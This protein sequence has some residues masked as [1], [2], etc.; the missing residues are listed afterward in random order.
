MNLNNSVEY[1][2][3]YSLFGQKIKDADLEKYDTYYKKFLIGE[4]NIDDFKKFETESIKKNLNEKYDSIFSND[5]VIMYLIT[6]HGLPVYSSVEQKKLFSSSE[7]KDMRKKQIKFIILHLY[8][9]Y[10]RSYIY[11]LSS[12]YR[13]IEHIIEFNGT[14]DLT[15]LVK[16]N[17]EKNILIIHDT[18][19]KIFFVLFTDDLFKNDSSIFDERFSEGK[20]G[21]FKSELEIFN[22]LMKLYFDYGTDY[23]RVKVHYKLGKISPYSSL[24][25]G[26]IGS[27]HK[28]KLLSKQNIFNDSIRIIMFL[29]R[30]LIDYYDVY[31]TKELDEYT[32]GEVKIYYTLLYSNILPLFQSINMHLTKYTLSDDPATNLIILRKIEETLVSMELK[33]NQPYEKNINQL[34]NL[35]SNKIFHN[36]NSLLNNIN[37]QHNDS[38]IFKDLSTARYNSADQMLTGKQWV[39]GHFHRFHSIV[40]TNN[41]EQIVRYCS[42]PEMFNDNKQI[43]IRKNVGLFWN[44]SANK[45][46]ILA[47]SRVNLLFPVRLY[48]STT[49]ITFNLDEF[50]K[51]KIVIPN[52][53]NLTQL[54]IMFNVFRPEPLYLFKTQHRNKTSRGRLIGTTLSIQITDFRLLNIQPG[55]F[56][57]EYSM[58][59]DEINTLTNY[60]KMNTYEIKT[61]NFVMYFFSY[62]DFTAKSEDKLLNN[63][64]YYM[65]DIKQDDIKKIVSMFKENYT[66]INEDDEDSIP[67]KK[68]NI[69]KQEKEN[70]NKNKQTKENQNEIISNIH[71]LYNNSNK[72]VLLKKKSIKFT[73]AKNIMKFEETLTSPHTSHRSGQHVHSEGK[74]DGGRNRR[75][76]SIIKYNISDKIYKLS[77]YPMLYNNIFL[78]KYIYSK[79]IKLYHFQIN[80]YNSYRQSI[81]RNTTVFYLLYPFSLYIDSIKENKPIKIENIKYK[82]ANIYGS[83]KTILYLDLYYNI[84]KQINSNNINILVLN[85]KTETLKYALYLF[86]KNNNISLD[87]CVIVFNLYKIKG[88]AN[89]KSNNKNKSTYRSD[90]GS[91]ISSGKINIPMN[92]KFNY[93]EK[94]I[95]YNINYKNFIDEKTYDFIIC[96]ISNLDKLPLYS[97]MVTEYINRDIYLDELIV[98]LLHLDKGG[99]ILLKV[100]GLTSLLLNKIIYNISLLFNDFSIVAPNTGALYSGAVQHVIFKS[101]KKNKK[102]IEVIDILQKLSKQFKQKNIYNSSNIEFD[103]NLK[104]VV[105]PDVNDIFNPTKKYLNNYTKLDNFSTKYVNY[106]NNINNLQWF[107]RLIYFQ[108]MIYFIK[109]IV[110]KPD[111]NKTEYI[112]KQYHKQIICSYLYSLTTPSKFLRDEFNKLNFNI[113]DKKIFESIYQ[114]PAICEDLIDYKC[115]N[116]LIINQVKNKLKIQTIKEKL[117]NDLY[118]PIAD[119]IKYF[120]EFYKVQ[121]LEELVSKEQKINDVLKFTKKIKISKAIKISKKDILYLNDLLSIKKVLANISNKD[122]TVLF[123]LDIL[124]I[125]KKTNSIQDSITILLYHFKKVHLWKSSFDFDMSTI[126]FIGRGFELKDKLT[127][128][129][130]EKCR[131][132][133]SK[134]INVLLHNLNEFYVDRDM[135]PTIYTY[136]NIL[137]KKHRKGLVKYAKSKKY[138]K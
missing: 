37:E 129:M 55:M 71:K 13:L 75:G 10:A 110:I 86:S 73:T 81:I 132:N 114:L 99:Y 16:Q 94:T 93:K 133:I 64:I 134:Y 46:M 121:K 18:N 88:Y 137:S 116:Q 124:D 105:H 126:Y 103:L 2:F 17:R 48:L 53:S 123:K 97:A 115:Y 22:E 52:L 127:K 85:N 74:I 96:T 130:I 1:L 76:G 78:S 69:N 23:N 84:I 60:L 32:I 28:D 5:G 30:G 21:K 77:N 113:T 117:D 131:H 108:N 90:R 65:F 31:M 20:E 26:N 111:F 122:I 54:G 95:T 3:K 91:I 42:C 136:Y 125:A 62:I 39:I 79:I 112:K 66:I 82:R 118:D 106:V 36:T 100:D 11:D 104:E 33:Y 50:I 45:I 135:I 43:G 59:Y 15:D 98:A 107:K 109:Y 24:Y 14:I 12:Q 7:D 58:V 34:A 9:S 56:E 47:A 29:I 67:N 128:D 72:P 61:G 27:N 63:N 6:P 138:I 92:N 68:A 102:N 120:N 83:W 4:Y 25:A 87:I 38:H 40:K 119:Y 51:Y 57:P 41:M 19:K 49:D 8:Q 80:N 35:I 70:R 89:I 44:Y 101:Y